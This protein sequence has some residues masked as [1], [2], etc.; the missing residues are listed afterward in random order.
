MVECIH[1]E[2]KLS[3]KITGDLDKNWQKNI[4]ANGNSF[5]LNPSV[6][7]EGWLGTDKQRN[8]ESSKVILL[9]IKDGRLTRRTEPLIIDGKEFPL[10][11]KIATGLPSFFAESFVSWIQTSFSS[12]V[13]CVDNFFPHKS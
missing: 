7:D 3:S 5:Q 4:V 6:A 10:K 1:N 13:K 11:E 2:S 12:S 8:V 9:E